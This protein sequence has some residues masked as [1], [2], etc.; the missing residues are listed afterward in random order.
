MCEYHVKRIE[1]LHNILATGNTKLV[2][3]R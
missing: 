1:K 3:K 2:N